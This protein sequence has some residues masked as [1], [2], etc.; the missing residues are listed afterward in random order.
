MAYLGQWAEY[1][2]T[3]M[4]RMDYWNKD[5]VITNL[6]A[7]LYRRVSPGSQ[8]PAEIPRKM[9]D[10]VYN[11]RY[12]Q[13]D[14]KRR[15]TGYYPD[16]PLSLNHNLMKGRPIRCESASPSDAG[17]GIHSAHGHP[18]D[19]TTQSDAPALIFCPRPSQDPPSHLPKMKCF[20]A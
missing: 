8:P 6:P 12:F 17:R 2:W 4:R 10:A 9:D 13:R 5:H 14:A 16:T 18:A 3:R 7:K 20:D 15:D 11:I 1:V 19:E